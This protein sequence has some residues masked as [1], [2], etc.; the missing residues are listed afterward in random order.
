[1]RVR[2]AHPLAFLARLL[3]TNVRRAQVLAIYNLSASTDLQ[4]NR[5]TNR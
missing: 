4:Q 1:M 3:M 2:F 5:F